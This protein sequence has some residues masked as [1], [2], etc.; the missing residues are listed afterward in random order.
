MYLT[1]ILLIYVCYSKDMT[2]LSNKLKP[3]YLPT[4]H[5]KINYQPTKTTKLDQKKTHDIV[6]HPHVSLLSISSHVQGFERTA[7][8]LGGIAARGGRGIFQQCQGLLPLLQAVG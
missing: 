5:M 2:W 6:H 4:K 8:Q 1:N 7:V 3:N